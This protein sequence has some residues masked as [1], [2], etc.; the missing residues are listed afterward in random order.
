MEDALRRRL[1]LDEMAAAQLDCLVCMLPENVLALTGYWPLSSFAIAIY[2]ID[3]EPVLLVV[4]LERDAAEGCLAEDIRTFGWGTIAAGDPWVSIER[5]LREIAAELRLRPGA[6]VGYEASFEVVAPGY[7]AGEVRAVSAAAVPRIAAALGDVDMVD[8]T[9]ALMRARRIKTPREIEALRRAHVVAEIGL[10]WFRDHTEAGIR[11]P[12]LAAGVE[13]GIMAGAGSIAGVQHARAWAEVMSGPRTSRAWSAFPL[14]AERR[15]EK[16]DLVVLE[17]AAVVDGFW[18]D[19][20]RTRT[21]G[22]ADEQQ[23]SAYEAILAAHRAA[24]AAVHPGATGTEVDAAARNTISDAGWGNGFV[25]HTG[26]GIGFRYHE[27]HPTLMPGQDTPLEVGMVS[28]LEPG[29]YMAGLGGLRR[30]EN[31]LITE[32]GPEYLS[33]FDHHLE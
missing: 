30:E 28:T 18:V 26:H 3:R 11:E 21:V 25:H 27:P 5:H 31:L 24:F 17:L 7:M 32:G 1:I 4:D 33:T 14:T 6:R 2:P 16:G 23:R 20:T 29:I 10:R 22:T 9:A 8:A 15:L 13:A 19:L 12:E